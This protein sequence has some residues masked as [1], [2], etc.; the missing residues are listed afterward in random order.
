MTQRKDGDSAILLVSGHSDHQ[1]IVV[2]FVRKRSVAGYSFD[3]AVAQL[4]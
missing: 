3:L 1:K 4:P 2:P